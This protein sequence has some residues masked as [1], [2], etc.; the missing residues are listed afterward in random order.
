MLLSRSPAQRP[1]E[2]AGR[3]SA[4]RVRDTNS[5]NEQDER[6]LTDSQ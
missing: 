2:A 3:V 1:G 6:K 5:L 4:V